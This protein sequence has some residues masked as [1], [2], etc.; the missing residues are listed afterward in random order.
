MD[1]SHASSVIDMFYDVASSLPRDFGHGGWWGPQQVAVTTM[2]LLRPGS[3]QSYKTVLPAVQADI[4]RRRWGWDRVPDPRGYS[5]ARLRCG[6][7]PFKACADRCRDRALALAKACSPE[8]R[9]PWGRT[10]AAFDGTDLLVFEDPGTRKRFGGVTGADGK[11]VG[12]PHALMVSA[13]DVVN[14][15]PLAWTLLPYGSDERIGARA[16]LP[17]LDPEAIAVFDRG[18]PSRAFVQEMLLA[19]RD[20]VMRMIAQKAAGWKEV[21]A[22]LR[23]GK[24]EAIVALDLG[25]DP[26]QP[27]KKILGMIRLI[28]RAFRVG[29]PMKHQKPET[30]VIATSLTAPTYS[31][32]DLIDVYQQRWGIETIHRELKTLCA[33]ETWHTAN[34]VLIEQEIAAIM[35]WQALA[36]AVQIQ[37]QTTLHRRRNDVWNTPTKA[38][39]VRTMVMAAVSEVLA[40]ACHGR[41]RSTAERI[42]ARQVALMADWAQKRRPGRSR[43]RVRIRPHGRFRGDP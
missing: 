34:P 28:R 38:L 25:P 5:D 4:G 39:A 12:Q 17:T 13:W 30:W 41:A 10:L 20:F 36:A 1:S 27:G 7:A 42:L 14:R 35:I 21:R 3:I 37:V 2:H 8:Q 6:V 19:G 26:R 31:R 32:E 15:I 24:Q 18:Y 23:S 43:P 9:G 16:L 40:H 22:F 11:P 29:K 33:V